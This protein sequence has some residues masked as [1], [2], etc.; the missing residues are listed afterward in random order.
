MVAEE[1]QQQYADADGGNRLGDDAG[2][3]EI[4]ERVDP[5]QVHTQAEQQQHR[6]T[7]HLGIR[8]RRFTGEEQPQPETAEVGHGGQ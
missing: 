1:Q 4:L 2:I 7:E 5:E 3:D 6:T 8:R